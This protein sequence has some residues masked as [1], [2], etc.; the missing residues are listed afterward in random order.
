MKVTGN[1]CPKPVTRALDNPM[2][3]D[4]VAWMHRVGD[5]VHAR[6]PSSMG[7]GQALH[8]AAEA[9]WRR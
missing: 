7:P 3:A 4:E 5:L 2:D 1:G 6:L 9:L 8:V